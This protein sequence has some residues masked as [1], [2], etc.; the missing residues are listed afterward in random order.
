MF[1]SPMSMFTE[2]LIVL[3]LYEKVLQTQQCQE[4]RSLCHGLRARG[5]GVTG[6]FRAALS[7]IM[8]ARL[9]AFLFVCKTKLIFISKAFHLASLL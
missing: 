5:E 1:I 4:L 9:S 8:K 2:M 3:A 7:L 6:H